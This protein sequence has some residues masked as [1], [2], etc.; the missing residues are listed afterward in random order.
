M[1]SSLGRADIGA[2]RQIQNGPPASRSRKPEA[3]DDSTSA[4]RA[5][6]V[7]CTVNRNVF[8]MFEMPNGALAFNVTKAV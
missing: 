2:V 1:P 3:R 6:P 5:E 8:E 7:Y 4:R